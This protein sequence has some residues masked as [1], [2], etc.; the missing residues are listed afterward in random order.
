MAAA[1]VRSKA[2]VLLLLMYCLLLL[3]L[4]FMGVFFIFDISL[5]NTIT[6]LLGL[7]IILINSPKGIYLNI[8]ILFLLCFEFSGT[9]FLSCVG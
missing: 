1:V 5:N 4:L 2:V 7:L 6:F 3:L 8:I 9:W